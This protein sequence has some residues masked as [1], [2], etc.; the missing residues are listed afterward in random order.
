MWH[1][2]DSIFFETNQTRKLAIVF[3]LKKYAQTNNIKCES[4]K[5]Y[6]IIAL[7]FFSNR[8]HREASDYILKISNNPILIMCELCHKIYSIALL[9]RS[10]SRLDRIDSRMVRLFILNALPISQ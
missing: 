8:P 9:R 10:E 2:I 3:F 1:T 5:K 4:C 6:V 7:F